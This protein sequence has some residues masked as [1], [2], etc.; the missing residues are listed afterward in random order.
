VDAAVHSIAPGLVVTEVDV[1]G[2]PTSVAVRGAGWIEAAVLLAGLEARAAGRDT[3]EVRVVS[4]LGAEA[5]ASIGSDGVVR[6]ELECGAVLDEIV[7]R[8][9]V[10][11]AAHMALGW[12]TSEGLAVAED[13][14]VS[15][16]T[17]RSFGILRAA[18]MPTVEVTL[19]DG[20]GEPTNGSDAAF[21]AVAAAAWAS[22]G[23]PTD[24]PTGRLVGPSAVPQ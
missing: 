8:S 14:T 1:A 22:Q 2:P 3:H 24:W 5:K 15:D 21:A 23:W 4:P 10:I 13:G 12:V 7:L 17:V 20:D 18:D 19:H 6:V 9:Y 11:G 16:L